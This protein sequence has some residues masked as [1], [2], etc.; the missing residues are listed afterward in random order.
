MRYSRN[1]LIRRTYFLKGK[2]ILNVGVAKNVALYPRLG[3]AFNRVKKNANSTSSNLLYFLEHGVVGDALQD[4]KSKKNSLGGAPG[5]RAKM[6]RLM[7]DWVII[8]NPYSRVLS[9]FLNKMPKPGRVEKWGSYNL[10][11]EGFT[12][13]LDWLSQGAISYDAHWNL[14]KNLFL[15]PL[16]QY[17]RVFKFEEFPTTFLQALE[18]KGVPVTEEAMR[19]V[20]DV[21]KATRT[22]ADDLLEQGYTEET[23]N[24]VKGLFQEDFKFLKYEA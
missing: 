5:E 4:V 22:N 15:L 18:D 20:H 3:I 23:W 2:Y 17:N 24:L 9:A 16:S 12:R 1:L 8:R 7:E 21:N 13:F 11:R 19:L 10:D 6:A 14:Q